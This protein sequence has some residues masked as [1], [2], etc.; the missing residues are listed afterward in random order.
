MTTEN[1]KYPKT[2]I[3]YLVSVNKFS[4]L[5]FFTFGI[6]PLWWMFKEWRFFM[7]KDERNIRPAL[8]AGIALIYLYSL[9]KNIEIFASSKQYN[10]K[11]Y[12]GLL[13]SGYVLLN[14]IS[15]FPYPYLFLSIFSFLFLIPS[16]K[17]LNYAKRQSYD[18]KVIEQ[19]KF[20]SGHKFIIVLGSIL[21]LL[22]LIGI[23]IN[24]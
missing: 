8:R 15:S 4:T 14:L 24:K 19:S 23:F 11:I 10:R 12:K 18:F 5:S 17:A 1:K 2:R 7:Q 20:S 16:F 3:Q 6:Y 13:F 21:W 9:F 22:I